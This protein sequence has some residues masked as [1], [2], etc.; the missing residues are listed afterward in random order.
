MRDINGGELTII[1]AKKIAFTQWQQSYDLVE[2]DLAGLIK[3]YPVKVTSHKLFKAPPRA[4]RGG[5][6]QWALV[7]EFL[8]VFVNLFTQVVA[9]GQPRVIFDRILLFRLFFFQLR[10]L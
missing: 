9:L 7:Q 2:R 3:Y 5:G 10:Q 1:T 4:S 6:H 8:C